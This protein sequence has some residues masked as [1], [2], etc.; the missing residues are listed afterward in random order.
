MVFKRVIDG[1][2]IF[3]NS[4]YKP[5]AAKTVDEYAQLDAE[6]ESLARWKAS[7]GIVPGAPGAA[8]GPKVRVIQNPTWVLI[9]LSLKGHHFGS[10]T[11]IYHYARRKNPCHEPPRQGSNRQS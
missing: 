4:G 5:G 10:R 1:L 11:C 8:S 2:L 6:D 3:H 9:D 7:L